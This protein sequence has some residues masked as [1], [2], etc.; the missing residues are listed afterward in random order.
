MPQTHVAETDHFWYRLGPEGIY[1]DSQRD[2]KAFA[3]TDSEVMLSEDN[4]ETW[5]HR[6]AFPDARN[7]T[8]SCILAGGNIVFATREKLYVSTDNL[9]TCEPV[10]VKGF[11]GSDY[12]PHTPQDPDRPGWYFHTLPGTNS[13]DVN[14][15]EMLV[16]GNYC[17]VVGGAT[18]VNI[19]YSTDGGVTVKLAYGFGQNPFTRDNG[20]PGGGP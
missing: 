4:G 14:G 13:W 15:T 8:F 17:N 18:P 6:L 19:Y 10:T 7:V 11:D 20:S 9:K 1:I 2:N 12:L 16:W 3:R 5:P